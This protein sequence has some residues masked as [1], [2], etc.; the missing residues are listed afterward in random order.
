MLLINN[1]F[2]KTG[3]FTERTNITETILRDS[4]SSYIE[5]VIANDVTNQLITAGVILLAAMIMFIIL[6]PLS[7]TK[8][9]H[10]DVKVS[11]EKDD[12]VDMEEEA[13][14]EKAD[15]V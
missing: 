10:K 2:V 7:N 4:P 5:G 1:Y 15:G 6:I 11:A 3:Y 8:V 12:L 9:C 14:N 13:E